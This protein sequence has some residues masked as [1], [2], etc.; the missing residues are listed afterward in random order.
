MPTTAGPSNSPVAVAAAVPLRFQTL[1]FVGAG[2]TQNTNPVFAD[3][4]P[5]LRAFLLQTAGAGLVSVQLQFADGVLAAAPDFQPLI[6][7][8]A[9]V[10]NVPSLNEFSL[11]SRQYRAVVTSTGAATVRVRLASVL[12]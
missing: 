5:G 11:G 6:P 3:G 1:T 8:F 10:L 9:I 12:S 4:L 2:G 7:A